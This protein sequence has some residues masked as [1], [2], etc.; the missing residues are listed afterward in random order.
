M[1]E[2]REDDPANGAHNAEPQKLRQKPY[3]GDAT[4]EQQDRDEHNADGNESCAGGSP[5]KLQCAK[6]W[7]MQVPVARSVLLLK[8]G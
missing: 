7:Q 4:I 5:V 8:A 3:V 2:S 6:E 1:R